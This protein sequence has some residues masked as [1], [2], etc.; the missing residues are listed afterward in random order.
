MYA[1]ETKRVAIRLREIDEIRIKAFDAPVGRVINRAL[2]VYVCYLQHCTA[3]ELSNKTALTQYCRHGDTRPF[4]VRVR[5]D[6]LEY[7]QLNTFRIASTVSSALTFY[8][9]YLDAHNSERSILEHGTHYWVNS[10][11]DLDYIKSKVS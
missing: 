3:E 2:E 11:I 4:N 9:N 8:I 6:L 10:R 7:L 1:T 5:R